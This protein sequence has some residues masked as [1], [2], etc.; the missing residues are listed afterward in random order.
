MSI[1]KRKLK[2]RIFQQLKIFF[3]TLTGM[4]L[5]LGLVYLTFSFFF[6]QKQIFISPLALQKNENRNQIDELLQKSG[7]AYTLIK[8]TND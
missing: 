7:I 8:K 1:K 2:I 5:L 6:P 4:F 3:I